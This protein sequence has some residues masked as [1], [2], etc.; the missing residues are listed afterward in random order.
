[1]PSAMTSA[2]AVPTTNAPTRF[3]TAAMPTATMGCMTRVE[4]TV[5]MALGA[6]VHP[7]A[8]SNRKANTMTSS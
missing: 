3:R 4:T 2:T 6:S 7:F 8:N 5:A 1:M